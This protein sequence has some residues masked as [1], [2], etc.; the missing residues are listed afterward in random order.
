MNGK[1]APPKKMG[2]LPVD[3]FLSILLISGGAFVFY[4]GIYE[5]ITVITNWFNT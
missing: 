5:F 1:S 2:Y 3:I 4:C